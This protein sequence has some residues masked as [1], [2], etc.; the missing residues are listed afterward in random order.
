MSIPLCIGSALAETEILIV[1]SRKVL[2][3]SQP[4]SCFERGARKIKLDRVA[5]PSLIITP[6]TSPDVSTPKALGAETPLNAISNFQ[7]GVSS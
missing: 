2:V 4:Q 5:P 6:I 1:S 3:L 7:N